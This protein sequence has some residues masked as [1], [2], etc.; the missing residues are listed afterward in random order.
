[1]QPKKKTAGTGTFLEKYHA[2]LHSQEM[3]FEEQRRESATKMD[4]LKAQKAQA[5]VCAGHYFKRLKELEKSNREHR[6]E[7]KEA[8]EKLDAAV[9]KCQDRIKKSHRDASR[10]AKLVQTVVFALSRCE[11][12]N[13]A[14]KACCAALR[15]KTD[16][17]FVPPID[18]PVDATS[19]LLAAEIA[20]LR[21]E[22]YNLRLE[23]TTKPAA[24]PEEDDDEVVLEE[25]IEDRKLYAYVPSPPARGT[26]RGGCLRARPWSANMP[27]TLSSDH[28]K[29]AATAVFAAAAPRPTS[30]PAQRHQKKNPALT[31][32][33]LYAAAPKEQS[34]PRTAARTTPS[35]VSPPRTSTTRRKASTARS[36]RRPQS[37]PCSSPIHVV[38]PS[39]SA[40]TQ[41]PGH[42]PPVRSTPGAARYYRDRK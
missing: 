42:R 17:Y 22:N 31:F 39:S 26:L 11:A 19:E 33:Q 28:R 36:H 24:E 35:R 10:S 1:M 15:M 34:S 14:L 6:K 12:E 38:V 8:K 4:E 3:K 29:D 32:R 41:K 21:E 30:A 9:E 40:A 16:E 37:A 13:A 27:L 23:L 18:A 2:V 20:E 7:R 5:E 25:P